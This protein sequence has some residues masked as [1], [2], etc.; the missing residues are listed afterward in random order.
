[1]KS[2]EL[3]ENFTEVLKDDPKDIVMISP[4]HNYEQMAKREQ[5][6]DLQEY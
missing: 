4:S 5:Y 2:I 3:M 6:R 1:M